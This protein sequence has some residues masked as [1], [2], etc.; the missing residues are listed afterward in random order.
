M[1]INFTV[2]SNLV[3]F[4]EFSH[5]IGNWLEIVSCIFHVIKSTIGWK[6]M[7]KK[8]LYYGKSM[9][10]NF[11]GLPHTMGFVALFCAMGN[12]WEDPCTSHMMKYTIGWE[13]D[14]N[15]KYLYYGNYMITNFPC[16]SHTMGFVAFCHAMGNWWENSC[17][18]IRLDWLIFSCDT[19][20]Y[21]CWWIKT[22][23]SNFKSQKT[24]QK[25]K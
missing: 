21:F 13:S 20:Q 15:K 11:P 6:L 4:A 16:S 17:L 5:A 14:R 10:T 1:G 18:P 3:D 7:G 2:F 25:L 19:F 23:C 12:W 9:S 22:N 8:H 24:F